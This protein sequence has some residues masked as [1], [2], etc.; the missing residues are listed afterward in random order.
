MND[1]QGES[2][3]VAMAEEQVTRLIKAK[4]P[5]KWWSVAFAVIIGFMIIGYGVLSVVVYSVHNQQRQLNAQQMQSQHQ[6]VLACQA[7]NDWLSRQTAIWEDLFQISFKIK[8]P[9]KHSKVYK[10]DQEFLQFILKTNAPR[11][12]GQIFSGASETFG[13]PPSGSGNP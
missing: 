2:L 10:I 11:N 3:M 1:P 9:D 8:P 13:P 7:R 12:C 6:A 4:A 5:P